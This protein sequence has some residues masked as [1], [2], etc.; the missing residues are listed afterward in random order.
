M[1]EGLHKECGERPHSIRLDNDQQ[2]FLSENYQTDDSVQLKRN[3]D[4][5]QEK[6]EV[7]GLNLIN[8]TKFRNQTEDRLEKIEKM[9]PK[10]FTIDQF[11]EES[12]TQETRTMGYINDK[13]G[14]F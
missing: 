7:I 2:N 6:L 14:I 11:R 4:K 5:L 10:C 12:Q 8:M 3:A 13:L 1:S 9:L